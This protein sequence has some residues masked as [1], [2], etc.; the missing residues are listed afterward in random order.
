MDYA[1]AAA[2]LGEA[3]RDSV[4]FTRWQQ[5]ELALM[6][7]DKAQELMNSYKTLQ[8]ELVQGSRDDMNK[9]ELEKIRDMLLDKQRELNE[10]TVTNNYF[11]A[12][13]GFESMMATINDIIQHFVTGSSGGCSGNC[14]SCAG[15][16]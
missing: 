4:E 14:S 3:I 10:N 16:H 9:E 15:C 5:A 1:E 7:N 6:Q 8:K 13:K 2:A 12:K 11:E